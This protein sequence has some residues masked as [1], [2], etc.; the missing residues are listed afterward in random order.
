M[1]RVVGQQRDNDGN[2]ADLFPRLQ[3][4]GRIGEENYMEGMEEFPRRPARD[5]ERAL[6]VHVPVESK[7]AGASLGAAEGPNIDPTA[8]GRRNDA[9]DSIDRGAV[10]SSIYVEA[11]KEKMLKATRRLQY[12]K[13]LR[14][15]A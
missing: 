8:D 11:R 13:P 6:N 3:F 2:R 15:Q 4:Q 10:Y 5:S 9:S 1:Q 14:L 7:L 12:F